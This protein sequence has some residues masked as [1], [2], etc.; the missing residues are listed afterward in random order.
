MYPQLK[1]LHW[2]PIDYRIRF[3]NYCV[4]YKIV[5]FGLPVYFKPY[6]VPY[7]SVANTRRANPEL[8]FLR[9][10][11]VSYDRTVHRSI[12]HFDRAFCVFGLALV[13]GIGCRNTLDVHLHWVLFVGS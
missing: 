1:A 13:T 4:T 7:T 3:K 5:N 9:E 6:F 2:L 11:I 10:D 12:A 8:K